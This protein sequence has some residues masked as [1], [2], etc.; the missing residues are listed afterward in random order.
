MVADNILVLRT[1]LLRHPELQLAVLDL[2][3]VQVEEVRRLAGTCR[4]LTI[5]S[6]HRS[7]NDRMWIA[8]LDAGAAEYC[9]PNDIRSIVRARRIARISELRTVR[10]AKWI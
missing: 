4:N 10:C 8:A 7:P 5:V 9:H 3:L 1:L 2:D 6:T